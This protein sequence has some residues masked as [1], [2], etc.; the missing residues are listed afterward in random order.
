MG[1]RFLVLYRL[2]RNTGF[3]RFGFST[4]KKVGKAVVRNRVK[5]ILKEICRLNKTWFS[6]G[7]DY[8]IIPKR[9]SGKESYN[10]FKEELFKLS[11]RIKK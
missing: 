6:E 7:Y 1:S 9:D 5:R 4:S 11:R 2:P 3:L 10:T 8:I